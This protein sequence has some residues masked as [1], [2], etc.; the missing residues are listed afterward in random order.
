MLKQ[1]ELLN[2]LKD[3]ELITKASGLGSASKRGDRASTRMIR[4]LNLTKKEVTTV[5][6]LISGGILMQKPMGYKHGTSVTASCKLGR[7]KPTKI[8]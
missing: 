4:S 6:T 3:E 5:I 7:N 2:K 8:T 1:E